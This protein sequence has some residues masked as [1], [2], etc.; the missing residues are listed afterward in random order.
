MKKKYFMNLSSIS[1][2][3]LCLELILLLNTIKY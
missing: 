2:M 1:T 3:E